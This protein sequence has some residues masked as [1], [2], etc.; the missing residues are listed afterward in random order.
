[1]KDTA[2]TITD[3]VLAAVSETK[4]FEPVLLKVDQLSSLTDY[5][6]ICSGRSTRQVQA[7]ADKIRLHLKT[8]DNRL[9]LGTEGQSEGRWVLLDYG[10]I[11]IHVF[12]HPLREFYDLEGLWSEAESIALEAGNGA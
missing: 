5:L 7:I 12:F 11:I 4:A 1:M 3:H 2:K 6:F 8:E 10:E 9:P